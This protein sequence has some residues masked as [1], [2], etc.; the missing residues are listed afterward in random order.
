[1]ARLRRSCA[2]SRSVDERGALGFGYG[3]GTRWSLDSRQELVDEV[4]GDRVRKRETS[5]QTAA[6]NFSPLIE[7]PMHLPAN[8][9]RWAMEPL[10]R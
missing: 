5:D 6:S 7:A 8:G 3:A 1:M 9:P 10:Q 4:V 2:A